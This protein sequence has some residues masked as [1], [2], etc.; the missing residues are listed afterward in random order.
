MSAEVLSRVF[1]PFYDEGARER[2][3]ALACRRSMDSPSNRE[4]RS[5]SKAKSAAARPS[6]LPCPARARPPAAIRPSIDV[7]QP[8]RKTSG[9]VLLVEDDNEVASLV[10][11]MLRRAGLR[12]DPRRK[13]GSGF[14]RSGR[15]PK[16]RRRL[17]R[18]HDARANERARSRKGNPASA[19]RACRSFLP[20]AT[21]TR[22]DVKPAAKTSE[23]CKSLMT[24]RLSLKPSRK[25]EPPITAP[26]ASD[27]PR[28]V[29]GLC[30]SGPEV[31]A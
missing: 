27:R 25:C 19:A 22:R 13:R 31:S 12:G 21:P 11:D 20:P 10:T 16:D 23:C 7:S 24:F 30:M 6:S 8:Q 29:G 2:A 4:D 5:A 28:P 18:H 1:E 3:Q 26:G 9:S 14:R 17:L 15:R